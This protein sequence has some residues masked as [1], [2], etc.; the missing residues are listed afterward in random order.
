M[1]GEGFLCL[2]HV[3]ADGRVFLILQA[4]LH[5]ARN[6]SGRQKDSGN[7]HLLDGVGIGSRGVEH[8]D[9]LFRAAL[10]RNVVYAGAGS[11]DAAQALGKLHIMHGSTADKNRIRIHFLLTY[12]ISLRQELQSLGRDRI[13]AYYSAHH[14]FSFSNFSMNSTSFCTPSIGI[15][16]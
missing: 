6:V 2:L 5:A 1:A 13:Q 8:H 7:H 14:A 10:Q 3:L 4:P 12:F 9:A 11:R 16:L 15:A